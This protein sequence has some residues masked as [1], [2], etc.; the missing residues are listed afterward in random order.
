MITG[1]YAFSMKLSKCARCGS[2]I[3]VLNDVNTTSNYSGNSEN[4]YYCSKCQTHFIKIVDI[5]A[6]CIEDIIRKKKRHCKMC[7]NSG[8][9]RKGKPCRECR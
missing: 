8:Y 9:D 4:S 1:D 3:I 2:N 5:K 6:D 7:N